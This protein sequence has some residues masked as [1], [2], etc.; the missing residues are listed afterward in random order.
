MVDAAV[1]A[2]LLLTA[3]DSARRG[4]AFYGSEIVTLGIA[5]GLALAG[6]GFVAH[7]FEQV[8]AVPPLFSRLAAS[9]L[10]LVIAHGLIQ[11]VSIPPPSA[12]T[13]PYATGCAG[14]GT[15]SSAR[16]R[17]RSWRRW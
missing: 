6:F 7:L 16:S 12:S 17:A 11:V 8:L 13:G 4:L 14:S 2:V 1:V 15:G 3:A 5:A 10:I 9:L